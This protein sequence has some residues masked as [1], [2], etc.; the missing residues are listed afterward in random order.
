MQLVWYYFD[1]LR[2]HWGRCE[3]LVVNGHWQNHT[4]KK[5]VSGGNHNKG[6][7]IKKH[8]PLQGETFHSLGTSKK[9]HSMNR[10]SCFILLGSPTSRSALAVRIG[11]RSASPKHR[12]MEQ[13]RKT[14]A[15]FQLYLWRSRDKN[16]GLRRSREGLWRSV[17]QGSG[18]RSTHRLWP[19]LLAHPKLQKVNE[20]GPGC[21]RSSSKHMIRNHC[22]TALGK[23]PIACYLSLSL[24][25]LSSC[26]LCCMKTLGQS[27]TLLV[28][29]SPTQT[30]HVFWNF[31]LYRR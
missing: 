30:L 26:F 9:V 18:T 24:D 20:S 7:W 1:W 17:T 15:A 22:R 31:H 14:A 4:E 28:S 5:M 10:A 8:T 6:I 16:I 29:A 21:L 2:C 19:S 25:L 13:S 3:D 11:T 23:L 27:T 12:K